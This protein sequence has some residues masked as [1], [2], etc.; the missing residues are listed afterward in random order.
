[1]KKKKKEYL[2]LSALKKTI[3]E[4]FLC[5]V[6]LSKLTCLHGTHGWKEEKHSLYI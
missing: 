2:A 3:Y 4:H 5:W 1:M 6:Y